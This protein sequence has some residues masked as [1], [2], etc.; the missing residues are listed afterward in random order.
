MIL[1]HNLIKYLFLMD[2]FKI[3]GII[4]MVVSIAF[5]ASP[6]KQLYDLYLGKLEPKDLS[7]LIMVIGL[8]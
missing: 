2:I 6:V 5:F 7:F 8:T 4:A 3:F 1:E